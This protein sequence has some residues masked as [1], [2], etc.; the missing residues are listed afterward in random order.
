MDSSVD[1]HPEGLPR[2]AAFQNSADNV[3][4]FRRFGWVH[5]RLLLSLQVEITTLE[6]RLRE[7]DDKDAED[8][9]TTGYRLR[10]TEHH[11]GWDSELNELSEQLMAK[12]LVYGKY[13]S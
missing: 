12:L 2:L 11:E 5:T 13:P 8:G 7:L 6:K 10:T 1:S 4:V 9:S 3:Y